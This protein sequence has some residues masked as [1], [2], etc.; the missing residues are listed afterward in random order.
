MKFIKSRKGVAL[1]AALVVVAVAA[2]GA[3]AYFS[4]TGSGT[5]SSATPTTINGWA[6][7]GYTDPGT[8]WPGI[9]D[10]LTTAIVTN[11]NSNSGP[12]HLNSVV[13]SITGINVIGGG[14]P[15]DQ[16]QFQFVDP[17]PGTWTVAGS[18][19]SATAT[20]IAPAQYVNPN[21]NAVLPAL[22]LKLLD[23]G[24]DQSGCVHTS[25]SLKT[26]VG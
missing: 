9:P 13:V 17:N 7:T 4:A 11:P 6:V 3:Y 5:G 19:T 1:L 14:R 18:G 20:L 26:L 25:V 21:S 2:V 10:G 8:L 15:C 23:S 16:S 24:V 22:D 12:L